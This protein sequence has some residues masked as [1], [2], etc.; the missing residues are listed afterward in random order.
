MALGPKTD[1][2]IEGGDGNAQVG[3]NSGTI[4]IGYTIEQH[5][6]AL[7]RTLERERGHL[8][9]AH[10][11]E[12]ERIQR[13]MAELQ[14]R[15]DN[16]E[17]DY[18]ERV[19]ELFEYKQ[20]L[21][22][23]SNQIEKDKLD[24][25]QKALDRGDD[26]LAEALFKEVLETVRNRREDAEQ[27]EAELEF[28]LGKIAE[29][30]ILWHDACAHYKRAVGLHETLGNLNAYARMTWRLA[31]GQEAVDAH[32]KIRD[33]TAKEF[34]ENSNEYATQ[35]N[36][37]AIVLK[38]QG[39]LGEAETLFR[40]AIAIAEK[41]LGVEHPAYAARLNNLAGVLKEQ[42]Q[43][44]EAETLYRKALAID[45]KTIGVDHPDYAT[46]LNNLARVL[47]VQGQFGEA[48][49]LYREALAIEE[50]TIGLAH[51]DYA[52]SLNNLGGVLFAQGLY[53]DAET[54]SRQAI[55][56]A[57]AALGAEHPST[58][59]GRKNLEILIANS[60]L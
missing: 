26:T 47:E 48:E 44:G 5:E 28:E 29:R 51:P 6:A 41:T 43:F 32:V 9:L 12:L 22:R 27:E 59:Q 52:R 50:K 19:E 55:K 8:K 16:K 7:E 10:G 35:L 24:A 15:L 20:K 39:Q 60:K 17:K 4:T 53:E 33:L 18:S 40:E 54:L 13:D 30:K 57:E 56:I 2:L 45:A 14:S 3:H 36:N 58:I 34:G 23:F 25:A 49:T 31:K 21:E 37:L 11:A 38:A 1:N 46:H 42:R